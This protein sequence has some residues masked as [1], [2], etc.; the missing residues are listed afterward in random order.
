[1]KR[2]IVLD[3]DQTCYNCVNAPLCHAQHKLSE[4]I[5]VWSRRRVFNT[6]SSD[7]K[8]LYVVL[9]GACVDFAPDPPP[10]PDEPDLETLIIQVS[11]IESLDQIKNIVA[12]A[13]DVHATALYT[14]DMK[15]I[16]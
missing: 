8:R 14:H 3:G 15:E 16:A 5:E 7:W 9:A 6:D 4:V 13:L 1:M 2:P 12:D 11:R 10:D